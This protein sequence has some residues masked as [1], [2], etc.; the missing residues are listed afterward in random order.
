MLKML[1]SAQ[2]QFCTSGYIVA[3]GQPLL[4]CS[5]GNLNNLNDYSTVPLGRSRLTGNWVRVPPN[6][7]ITSD[8]GDDIRG[9]NNI[10]PQSVSGDYIYFSRTNMCKYMKDCYY[11]DAGLDYE[12]CQEYWT[13]EP[14]CEPIQYFYQNINP[15]VWLFIG[16]ILALIVLILAIMFLCIFRYTIV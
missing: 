6:G 12:S 5:Y 16:T 2:H 3:T 14:N 8:D 10:D 15:G 13:H 11:H 1:S 4:A 9:V 7:R